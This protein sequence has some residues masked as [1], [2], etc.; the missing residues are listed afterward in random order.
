MSTRPR[1]KKRRNA[2]PIPTVASYRLMP[3]TSAI[4]R[5]RI[6]D[7][8]VVL[9]NGVT[10]TQ[11]RGLPRLPGQVGF[12]GDLPV[13]LD[14]VSR[15]AEEENRTTLGPLDSFESG[16]VG[17]P[18]IPSP[19][20]HRAKRRK[21]WECWTTEILPLILPHYLEFQRKTRSLRDKVSL[22]M[23]GQSCAC[24]QTSRKLTIWVIR[25]SSAC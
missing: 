15:A 9:P 11:N 25:F 13:T 18:D 14:N 6:S 24:C 19:S 7:V 22:D 2:L 1:L 16:W 4:R 10:M 3:A 20:K 21:Q 8:R 23:R 17:L 12:R 5:N